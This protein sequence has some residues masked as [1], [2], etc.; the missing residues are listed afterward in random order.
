M[1]V[2]A[3][4]TIYDQLIALPES[5]K[6]GNPLTTISVRSGLIFEVKSATEFLLFILSCVALV[7]VVAAPIA[8]Q[9]AATTTY[10]LWY[11]LLRFRSLKA[12]GVFTILVIV[13]FVTTRY[14]SPHNAGLNT[15]FVALFSVM[16][17]YRLG[18]H[19]TTALFVRVPFSSPVVQTGLLLLAVNLLVLWTQPGLPELVLLLKWSFVATSVMTMAFMAETAVNEHRNRLFNHV[20]LA[21]WKDVVFALKS[22]AMFR[23]ST[24]LKISQFLR[25]IDSNTDDLEHES[26]TFESL[27]EWLGEDRAVHIWQF[28]VVWKQTRLNLPFSADDDS[29]PVE[30]LKRV[31]QRK[32][33]AQYVTPPLRS[34]L[35]R[36]H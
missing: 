8:V 9:T 29:V 34:P 11:L 15:A 4:M 32:N 18:F 33:S 28:L 7:A 23:L 27:N 24:G 30:V 36:G 26:I 12:G 25:I 21:P 3:G 20:I 16:T 14:V 1:L 2:L 6:R 35:L 13:S 5:A 17:L 19:P 31:E 22:V 10:L